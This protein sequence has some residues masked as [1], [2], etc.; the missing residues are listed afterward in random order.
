MLRTME[1]APLT[2]I[3]EGLVRLTLY[4]QS[5]FF[6]PVSST[7]TGTERESSVSKV[8]VTDSGRMLVTLP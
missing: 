6:S 2:V 1:A 5:A 8:S 4:Q 7:L 3:T